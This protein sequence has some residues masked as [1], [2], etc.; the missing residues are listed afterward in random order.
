[1]TQTKDVKQAFAEHH[2]EVDAGTNNTRASQSSI[3]VYRLRGV[4]PLE[5]YLLLLDQQLWLRDTS[6]RDVIL[7]Q[8]FYQEMARW[9]MCPS[10]ESYARRLGGT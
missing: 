2:G 1:M 6:S 4:V 3:N 8:C 5:S 9:K 10:Q 7:I